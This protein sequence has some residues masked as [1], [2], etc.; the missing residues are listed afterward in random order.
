M[1]GLRIRKKGILRAVLLA[2]VFVGTLTV[3]LSQQLLSE[4]TQDDYEIVQGTMGDWRVFVPRKYFVLNW[5]DPMKEENLYLL[6]R[7]P[8][9]TPIV[10]S[11]QMPMW[12][13]GEWHKTIRVLASFKESN[14][15]SQHEL[16]VPMIDHLKAYQVV[17]EEHGLIHQTQPDG[18]V[19]DHWDVWLERDHNTGQYLSYTTCTEMLTASSV[20]QC[21]H[22]FTYLVPSR[23]GRVKVSFDKRLLLQWREIRNDVVELFDSFSSPETAR[24]FIYERER[25]ASEKGR[26]Q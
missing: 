9:L 15:K 25:K 21:S 4:G 19:K 3:A 7:Y 17:G 23:I 8:E 13:R 18:Y 14:G 6:M 2:L 16:T 11:E 20:P 22:H 1:A 26:M 5:L 10:R 24:A 12:K